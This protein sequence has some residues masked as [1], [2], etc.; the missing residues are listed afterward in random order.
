MASLSREMQRF[1]RGFLRSTEKHTTRFFRVATLF[2]P[3]CFSITNLKVLYCDWNQYTCRWTSPIFRM[4]YFCPVEIRQG[5]SISNDHSPAHSPHLFV[6]PISII[7][8]HDPSTHPVSP[9]V[10][11]LTFSIDCSWIAWV[12]IPDETCPI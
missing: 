9:P 8:T 5:S 7:R 6:T 1:S 4:L 10:S 2:L 11:A 3:I 12:A